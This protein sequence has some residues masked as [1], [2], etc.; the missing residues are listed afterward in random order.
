MPIDYQQIFVRIKEIGAG[1]RERKKTLEERRLKAR[2]LLAAYASELD[3]LCSKVDS[4]TKV[5]SNTR[6]AYPLNEG[7]ASH[8]PPPVPA[9]N[10]TLI[11]ADGSQINPDRH[12]AV[13]FCVVNVGAIQMR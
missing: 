7:L 11:A 13:Q 10:V 4:A 12:A 9:S 1:A 2:D 5:D 3:V 8:Y 6:C